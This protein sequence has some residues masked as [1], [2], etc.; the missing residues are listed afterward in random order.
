MD[1]AYIPDNSS[2]HR[3]R[4]ANK[5]KTFSPIGIS[6]DGP[7]IASNTSIGSESGDSEEERQKT[8]NN[9]LSQINSTPQKSPPTYEE[10]MAEYK[11]KRMERDEKIKKRAQERVA[12]EKAEKERRRQNKV[13]R[14]QC[15]RELEELRHK[16]EDEMKFAKRIDEEYIKRLKTLR[17]KLNS[18]LPQND[19]K[20]ARLEYVNLMEEYRCFK[21]RITARILKLK[22]QQGVV[23]NR[24]RELKGKNTKT[25]QNANT[26]YVFLAFLVVMDD[27]S[28]QI[29]ALSILSSEDTD[30]V[31]KV[32]R[33]TLPPN[34]I[35]IISDNGSQFTSND[36]ED[37]CE[38]E[39]KV[40]HIRIYPHNPREN[41][42]VERLI[43]TIKDLL[44]V[45]EWTNAEEAQAALDKV[46]D[47]YNN[48]P[49]QSL[50]YLTPLEYAE[51][52]GEK[53]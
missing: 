47:E 34:V 53:M 14:A 10:R 40:A 4:R 7:D 28:R 30:A 44:E 19:R 16:L 33:A 20:N 12:K 9:N 2:S 37:A 45:Y 27:R 15:R 3:E 23:K 26:L 21:E 18:G 22:A 51:M 43:R 42:R 39:F 50:N 11:R 31:I 5:V 8:T 52:E 48:R 13:A 1:I 46:T 24:L 49:H 32:L 25:I 35:F 29:Y 38:S 17:S 6:Q 36:F 41:G